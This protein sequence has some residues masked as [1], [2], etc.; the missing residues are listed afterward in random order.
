MGISFRAEIVGSDNDVV[1]KLDLSNYRA[2]RTLLNENDD[3]AGN[4]TIDAYDL[5]DI[6]PAVKDAFES[7]GY[8]SDHHGPRTCG[9]LEEIVKIHCS[10]NT[11][12]IFQWG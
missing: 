5:L 11:R 12:V 1:A 3:Y 6:L 9:V 8:S 7:C 10:D 2:W 4:K